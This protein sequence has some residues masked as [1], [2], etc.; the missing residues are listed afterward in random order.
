MQRKMTRAVA[1]LSGLLALAACSQA[2]APQADGVCWRVDRVSGQRPKFSELARGVGNLDNC[3]VLLE[4][5]R[6]QG[7]ASADGAFHGYFIFVDANGVTSAKHPDGFR[8]PIFQPP[9]RLEVD[10][11]LQRLMKARGGRLPDAAELSLERK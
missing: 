2:E 7:Q 6:L 3:A 9:Q 4:A 1:V 10:R 8:Y 11:E 5:V